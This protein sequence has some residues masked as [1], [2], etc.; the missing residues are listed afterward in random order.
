MARRILDRTAPLVVPRFLGCP[1]PPPGCSCL[2]SGLISAEEEG[3]CSFPAMG[4]FLNKE[5]QVLSRT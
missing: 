3:G 5:A 4:G 2:L 1:A